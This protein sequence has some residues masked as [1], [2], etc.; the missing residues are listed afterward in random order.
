MDNYSSSGEGD[1]YSEGGAE[2]EEDLS[3]GHDAGALQDAEDE[4]VEAAHTPR[5]SRVTVSRLE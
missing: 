2:L 1:D 3:W 4:D 5:G